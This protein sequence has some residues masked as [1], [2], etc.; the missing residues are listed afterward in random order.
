MLLNLVPYIL[1]SHIFTFSLA[2]AMG[3]REGEVD[4]GGQFGIAAIA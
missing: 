4:Q 1:L 2:I 3:A